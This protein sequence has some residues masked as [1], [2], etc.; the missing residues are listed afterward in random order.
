MTVQQEDAVTEATINYAAPHTDGTLL[1]RH[2]HAKPDGTMPTNMVYE[3]H[4]VKIHDIG[5]HGKHMRLHT[6]G[7]ELADVEVPEGI[8]WSDT[9]QV[10]LRRVSWGVFEQLS[11]CQALSRG[12]E[13]ASRDDHFKPAADEAVLQ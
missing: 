2:V 9:D 13:I 4:K 10:S 5:T 1:F 6:N 7:F 12:G 8:D 11:V 3:P